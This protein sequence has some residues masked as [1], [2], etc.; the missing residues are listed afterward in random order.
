MRPPIGVPPPYGAPPNAYMPRYGGKPMNYPFNNQQQYINRQQQ[1]QQQRE[2]SY[3]SDNYQVPSVIKEKQL[4][5]LDEITNKTSK[6]NQNQN[7]TNTSINTTSN[8]NN[9]DD[10]DDNWAYI[11]ETVDYK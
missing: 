3:N 10:L 4:N 9:N 11:N 2:A 7:T 5:H 6:I 8:N 1:Q